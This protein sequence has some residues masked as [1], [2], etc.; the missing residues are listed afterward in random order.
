MPILAL[1]LAKAGPKDLK[2]R[3]LRTRNQ[4]KHNYAC[5]KY[6]VPVFVWVM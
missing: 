3:I 1:V 5:H 4:L 2:T 6:Y